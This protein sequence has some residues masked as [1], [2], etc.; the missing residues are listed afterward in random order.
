MSIRVN[1]FRLNGALFG[2][3]ALAALA[4]LSA[5]A[6]NVTKE[7]AAKYQAA[8]AANQLGGLTYLQFYSKCSAELRSQNAAPAAP[9]A[10][11][12]P[13]P[14]AAE[15]VTPAAPAA[16]AAPAKP[17]RSAVKPAAAPEAPVAVGAATFPSAVNPAYQTEKPG[18]AIMKTCLDQYKANKATNGN[19]G[20][21]W[22]QKGGGYYS[23]CNKKLK[24]A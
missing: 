3:V 14:A 4:P 21:K 11:A 6:E 23:E 12:A 5:R 18:K 10:P 16:S 20:L 8:K 9:P 19:G 1:S 13:A 17:L 2:A 24:G 22:I 7:C 15:P